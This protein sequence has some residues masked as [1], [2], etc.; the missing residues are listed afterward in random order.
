MST[1]HLRLLFCHRLA[2][3][4]ISVHWRYT[5]LIGVCIETVDDL[6]SDMGDVIHS[7]LVTYPKRP[8]ESAVRR[9]LEQHALQRFW[10]AHDRTAP[11][12]SKTCLVPY[13]SYP[14]VDTPTTPISNG[15]A[16]AD[17][18]GLTMNQL[19]SFIAFKRYTYPQPDRFLHYYYY[20]TPK[21]SGEYRLIESPKTRL[22]AAQRKIN[23]EILST[24]DVHPAAHGY[25]SQHSCLTHAAQHT[26]KKHVFLFDLANCFHSITW[27]AVYQ[28]FLQAGYSEPLSIALTALCTHKCYEGHPVISKLDFDRRMCLR[29]RHLPQG[30]PTSPA[31]SNLV[32]AHVDR[33]LH[34]VALSLNMNYTRYADDLVFSTNEDRNWTF[35]EALVGNICLEQ[36]FHLNHR[37]SRH[38]KQHQRQR[39][40]GLVV[41]AKLN[42]NRRDYDNLKATLTNCV[43]YGLESQ[44]KS[45]HPSFRQ[46]LWGRVQYIK[47]VSAIKGMK[48]ER[49]FKQLR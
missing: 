38:L 23:R 15:P 30:A 12:V 25:R 40:T 35:L 6:P 27:P 4:L 10:F 28:V 13:Q 49:I 5:T 41:N 31:L 43:R 47:S 33:R 7:M 26:G 32:L 3:W 22:K 42:I 46:H 20:T 45:A 2:S 16:L 36:G 9:L 29:Q 37:K 8:T 19:D 24:L 44:N 34:A 11:T 1:R 14:A 17:W 18:L 39:V 48:L 21:R